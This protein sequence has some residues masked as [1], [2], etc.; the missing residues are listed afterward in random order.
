[1][2]AAAVSSSR[3]RTSGRGGSSRSA[4][5]RRA[6]S[7]DGSWKVPVGFGPERKSTST[8][9]TR[10]RA[11][12]DV[13]GAACR[14]SA[15]GAPSPRSCGDQRRRDDARRRPRRTR[16]PSACPASRRRRP[17]RRPGTA[18][19]ASR[20][21]PG[22]SRRRSCRSRCTTSGARCFGTPRKRSNG[23]SPPS[24]STATPRAA[25]ERAR[26]G[27]RGRSAMPRSANAASSAADVSGDGGTGVANGITS[28]IS[29]PSRT[30]R[31]DERSRAAAARTRSAPAGT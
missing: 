17:R 25:V 20:S 19:R 23:S 18:S 4:P 15:A 21:R 28:V 14:R 30:P 29:Q 26:P 22:C 6:S 7:A 31:C 13:A 3:C 12:L 10:P 8:R 27:G 9:P 5:S 11:E 1:M 2:R 24:S 16:R